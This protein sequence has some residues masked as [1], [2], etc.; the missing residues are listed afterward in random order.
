LLQSQELA[1]NY[2]VAFEKMWRDKQFGRQKKPGGTTPK[3]TINGVTVESYFSPE[4][5][6]A[7]KVAARLRSAQKSIDFMAFSFTEDQIG[8][9]VRDR[10]K[11]GVKVRGVFERTGSETQFS[12]FGRMRSDGLEV[13][14]DGNPYLMHHKVFVIDGRTVI[15]GSFNFSANANNSNDENLLMV[16]DPAMAGPFTAEFERVLAQAKNPPTK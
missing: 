9:V 1:R 15:T 11:A 4:D 14:Q 8:S 7:D 10:A 6:V 12:E 2:T 3:L 13:L 5:G 16:D